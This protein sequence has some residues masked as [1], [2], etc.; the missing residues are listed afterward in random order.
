M[1]SVGCRSGVHWIA[2][3]RRA[4]DRLRDRAREHRLGRSGHVLE[5]HVAA[6]RERGEDE[7]DLAP[8]AVDD[9][10]DV[11]EEAVRDAGCRGRAAP[12]SA[13]TPQVGHGR[14]TL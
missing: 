13:A 7:L 3:R 2:R 4:L 1:T 9:R 10:L 8:L 12:V 6:A 11:G 14:R 5:E